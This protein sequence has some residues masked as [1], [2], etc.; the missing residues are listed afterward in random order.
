MKAPRACRRFGSGCCAWRMSRPAGPRSRSRTGS[1]TSRRVRRRKTSISKP[2]MPTRADA[3]MICRSGGRGTFAFAARPTRR[4]ISTWRRMT[5]GNICTTLSI[6]RA[7]P[8]H[9]CGPLVA[10]PHG[11]LFR[12][13]RPGACPECPARRIYRDRAGDR[14]AVAGRRRMHLDATGNRDAAGRGE[15]DLLVGGLGPALGDQNETGR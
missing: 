15:P 1:A 6:T 10:L 13:G 9:S 8:A 2:A 12:L 5:K 3:C 11:H 4:L 14:C 7:P